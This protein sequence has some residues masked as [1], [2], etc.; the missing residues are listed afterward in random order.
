MASQIL[1][2]GKG[3]EQDWDCSFFWL[4]SR[5][6]PVLKKLTPIPVSPETLRVL[7]PAMRICIP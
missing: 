4:N 7:I 5:S 6:G 1:W 2:P 3:L